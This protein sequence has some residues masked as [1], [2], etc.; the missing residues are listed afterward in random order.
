MKTWIA[1][2]KRF[3][4]ARFPDISFK[5]LGTIRLGT[6]K[7]QN[8]LVV[9]GFQGG[10]TPIFTAK[11]TGFI[12]VFLTDKQLALGEESEKIIAQLNARKRAFMK[13][14]QAAAENIE[15]ED[16]GMKRKKAELKTL[17]NKLAKGRA[18]LEQLK[19]EAGRQ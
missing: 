16:L 5:A 2:T 18:H 10:E 9:E 13:Q 4:H 6:G 8:R 17:E 15:M 12:K 19:N 11:E 7:F 14:M 3:L 1:K